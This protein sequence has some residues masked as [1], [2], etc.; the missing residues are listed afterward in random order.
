MTGKRP[1]IIGLTGSIGMGKSTTAGMFRDL[2]VDVWDADEAVER[3]YSKGGKAVDAIAAMVPE[4]VRNGAVD[5]EKLRKWFVAEPS[6]P[7]RLEAL[8]H[9]LVAQDRARFL[10]QASSDIVV[11]DIPLLFET[12]T[13]KM[14]DLAVVVSV[15]EDV[16]R[17]RVLARGDMTEEQFEKIR[18]RQMPDAQKRRRA[19][20]VITTNTLDET[21]EAVRDLVRSIR[22]GDHARTSAGY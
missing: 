17:R 19:D 1:F 13:D 22:K 2:G 6:A 9:P 10:E 11:L 15:P 3:L 16:Q 4:A 14:V 20:V 8:V 5:R 12:G 7:K 18:A 21:R